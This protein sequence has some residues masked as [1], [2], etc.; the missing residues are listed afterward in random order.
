MRWGAITGRTFERWLT[1]WLRPGHQEVTAKMKA[2][3]DAGARH[4]VVAVAAPADVQ[5]PILDRFFG[6][7][8]PALLVP[9]C[10]SSLNH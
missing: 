2:F 7:V 5:H 8:V 10:R 3:Y 6:D 4:F 9:R 1:V